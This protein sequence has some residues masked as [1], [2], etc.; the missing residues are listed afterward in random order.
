MDIAAMASISKYTGLKQAVGISVA[1]LTMDQTESQTQELIRMMNTAA[2]P[3]L[4]THIDIK[5]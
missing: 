4:G 1:K 5:V 3:G 2:V